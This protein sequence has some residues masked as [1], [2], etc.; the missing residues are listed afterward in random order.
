MMAGGIHANRWSYLRDMLRVLRPGGWYQMVEIY[1]N[2]KSDNG[3]LERGE[4][5]RRL[6]CWMEGSLTRL[7]RAEHA[8]SRWS[9]QYLD[10]LHPHKDLRAALRL[11]AWLRNAGFTEVESRLLSLPMGAWPSGRE[12]C[13][14][15][16]RR[17]SSVERTTEP[18]DRNVGI[19]NSENVAQLL[20]SLAL[21]PFTQIRG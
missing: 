13:P 2:A 9:S 19:A 5:S 10:S 18:R 1:F 20:Y 8:L 4:R 11:P 12:P 6:E 14:G 3:T 16:K 21:Y 7:I 17:P 15:T